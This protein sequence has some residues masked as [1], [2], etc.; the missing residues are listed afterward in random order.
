[1]STIAPCPDLIRWA[2]TQKQ[3]SF[4]QSLVSYWNR[5]GRLTEKQEAALQSTFNKAQSL[6]TSAPA[7]IGEGMYKLGEDIIKVQRAVH[8][9]GRLYA[10]V[11]TEDT[12]GEWHFEYSPGIMR[13]LAPSMKL[14]FEDAQTFGQLYGVCCVCGRTLTDE[15]SIELGIGPVCREKF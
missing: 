5:Y 12:F 9:S 14:S 1:M 15:T 2:E 8:G 3:N 13:Q 11:L 4:C 6:G 7:T 10:K